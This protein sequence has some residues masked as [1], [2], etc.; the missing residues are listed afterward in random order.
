MQ[1]AYD[2]FSPSCRG[3]HSEETA[4]GASS[5]Y[6]SISFQPTSV[7]SQPLGSAVLVGP[8]DENGVCV[9]VAVKVCVD[10]QHVPSAPTSVMTLPELARTAAPLRRSVVGMT[11]MY[12]PVVVLGQSQQRSWS[13]GRI[14]HSHW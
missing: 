5:V 12:V 14:V 3:D 9:A 11:S 6:G 4:G 10:R 13:I 7:Y 8:S 1:A 2:A